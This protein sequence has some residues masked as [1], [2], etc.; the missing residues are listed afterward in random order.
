M[1]DSVADQLLK[2]FASN[3]A[4]Q[5]QAKQAQASESAAPVA[6]ASAPAAPTVESQPKQLNA[7]SLIWAVIRDGLRSL[8]GAKRT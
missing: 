2:Q 4:A 1:I 8:F 7:L 3:F 5:V 6:K